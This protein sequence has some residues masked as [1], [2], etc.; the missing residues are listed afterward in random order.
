MNCL[1]CRDKFPGRISQC[2]EGEVGQSIQCGSDVSDPVCFE[3]EYVVFQGG[4]RVQKIHRWCRSFAGV[5]ADMKE[6]LKST[7]G[8]GVKGG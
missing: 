3:G 5:V 1:I 2:K 6:D 8:A 4:Q 7:G